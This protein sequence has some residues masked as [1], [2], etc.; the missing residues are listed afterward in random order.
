MTIHEVIRERLLVK[1]GLASPPPPA[2]TTKQMLDLFESEATPEFHKLMT[3]RLVMGAVRYG[4]VEDAQHDKYGWNGKSS[5]RIDRAI[6]KLRTWAFTGNDELLIDAANYCALEMKYGNHPTKHFHATDD[7][8]HCE[9]NKEMNI[10]EH[11]YKNLT[12]TIRGVLTMQGAGEVLDDKEQE[13][14]A[15]SLAN[16]VTFSSAKYIAGQKEHGGKITDRNLLHECKMENTD[17][18]W[19]LAAMEWKGKQDA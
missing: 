8:D 14:M 4:K 9:K 19:Y 7:E 13:R 1:S 17:L 18:F 12:A 6:N 11:D 3:N 10:Q 16:F 2:Y 5:Q 15:E